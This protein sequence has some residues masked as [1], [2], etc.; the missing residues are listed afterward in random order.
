MSRTDMKR[1]S[2]ISIEGGKKISSTPEGESYFK[3]REDSFIRRIQDGKL[4]NLA[5]EISDYFSL[6]PVDEELIVK[7][8]IE[9]PEAEIE[10]THLNSESNLTVKPIELSVNR[11]PVSS[12]ETLYDKVTFED[13]NYDPKVTKEEILAN[14]GERFKGT[15]QVP[16]FMSSFD[17]LYQISSM[18][19]MTSGSTCSLEAG[20][21]W[22]APAGSVEAPILVEDE[23]V[24]RFEPVV[25]RTE[26]H[27]GEI[28][29]MMGGQ[30]CREQDVDSSKKKNEQ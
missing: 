3:A 17:E 5:V 4:Q 19:T 20:R 21:R 13:I 7:P 14:L 28:E 8:L 24:V 9:D 1:L 10:I 6:E 16:E 15:V 22:T 11:A 30:S 26:G 12:F 2:E 29:R 27:W 25:E 18:D 23:F